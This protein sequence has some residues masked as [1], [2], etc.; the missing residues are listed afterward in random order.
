MGK[1]DSVL[2]E[3]HKLKMKFLKKTLVGGEKILC[4][5]RDGAD[6]YVDSHIS[7]TQAILG[8]M[9]DVPTLSGKTQV[10]IPKGVQPGKLLV[11]RGHGS[12]KWVT[13]FIS[14]YVLVEL[15][16]GH[17]FLTD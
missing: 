15:T 1:D 16:G 5:T 6:I 11:L 12:W 9:V 17:N 13:G 4:F 14:S 10:K 7:F 3:L 2:E 8:G